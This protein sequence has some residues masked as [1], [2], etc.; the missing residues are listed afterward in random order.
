MAITTVPGSA[1][2]SQMQVDTAEPRRLSKLKVVQRLMELGAWQRVKAKI[3]ESGLYDLFLAAQ[4]FSDD[5]DYFKQ[6]AGA[7]AQMLGWDDA[8]LEDEISRCLAD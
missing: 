7:I 5:N 8:R 1:P 4:V 2:M 3:E 6:G